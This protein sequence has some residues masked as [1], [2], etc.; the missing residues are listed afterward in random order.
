[1]AKSVTE[2][3]LARIDKDIATLQGMRAYVEA[4]ASAEAAA[5]PKVRKARKKK[6]LPAS[7]ETNSGL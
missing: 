5:E 1:M 6:G 3:L 2:V 7:I 4:N